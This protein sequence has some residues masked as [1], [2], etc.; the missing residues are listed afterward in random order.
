[1]NIN[2]DDKKIVKVVYRAD[3]S[4]IIEFNYNDGN[5]VSVNTN[6]FCNKR[7][8]DDAYLQGICD[9]KHEIE[10]QSEST[11]TNCKNEKKVLSDSEMIE[12]VEKS[13]FM[14]KLKVAKDKPVLDDAQQEAIGKIIKM[15]REGILDEIA[16]R[17]GVVDK[18]VLNLPSPEYEEFDLDK[19]KCKQ[20]IATLNHEIFK[21]INNLPVDE[22]K[23]N[24][25]FFDKIE[26]YKFYRGK[27]GELID[28]SFSI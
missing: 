21:L 26:N 2:L 23:D 16:K 15:D 9:S 5:L 28:K 8:I 13:S 14:G 17:S 11:R 10:K 22:L 27:M 7:E 3:D 24:K 19:K 4:R 20:S 1:M 12:A 18:C 25:E 6:E